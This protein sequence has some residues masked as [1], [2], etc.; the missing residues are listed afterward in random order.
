MKRPYNIEYTTVRGST[1]AETTGS[2][3]KSL[4]V[5]VNEKIKEGWDLIG[6][7]SVYDGVLYQAMVKVEPIPVET[8]DGTDVEI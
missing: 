1:H 4:E 2:P 8:G 7:V 6:G 3:G 5:R